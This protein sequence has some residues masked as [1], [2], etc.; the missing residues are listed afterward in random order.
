M[1]LLDDMLALLPDNTSGDISAADMRTI[2]T[3]L[4]NETETKA[5][6]ASPTFTGTVAGITKTMVG[7]GSVDN[8]ADS[9]KP[10]STSQQT[11]IQGVVSRT[12][13]SFSGPTNVN[14]AASGIYDRDVHQDSTISTFSGTTTITLQTTN[15][16]AGDTRTLR[17]DYTGT[18]TVE[19]RN[20]TS[21][22]TLLG[23]LPTTTGIYWVMS[24]YSGTAW[25]AVLIVPENLISLLAAKQPLDSDL[26]TIAGLTPTSDNFI[27]SKSSAWASRT[28]AQ[29]A[30]DLQSLL[31]LTES[32][33]TNL[34]T[35]LAAK[36]AHKGNWT[37]ST[38]YAVNDFV[39]F[40][41]DV[42]LCTTGHT[43]SS[44]FDL[45]KWKVLTAKPGVFNV[46]WYG[47]KG[48]N[49]TD[50]TAAIKAASDAA[51]AY[52]SA[53]PKSA[54]VLFPPAV[55]LLSGATTQ[56]SSYDGNSQIPVP[57]NAVAGQ[58]LT[59]RYIGLNDGSALPHWQQTTAQLG[60]ATL[61][62]TITQ[63]VDGTWGPPSVLGGPTPA[64]GY[65]QSSGTFSNEIGRAHV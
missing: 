39:T 63:D 60:G 53:G 51:G 21:S 62:S 16:Q 44:S 58:K 5:P 24:K 7:L 32:Q 45:T 65:G 36:A 49:S 11:A 40:A 28:P 1:T 56:S 52:A 8:T 29:V 9:A 64:K 48:D 18:G 27:Q 3:D 59:I 35:D 55:Y 25:S 30:A 46:M 50:D 4:F 34:T 23:T 14:L 47:A 15:A 12:S 10:V 38:V 6:I 2:V 31:T 22:G 37:A 43:S 20:G 19:I 33:V 42:M 57:L 41:G 17:L 13:S 61:R 26:T 54:D